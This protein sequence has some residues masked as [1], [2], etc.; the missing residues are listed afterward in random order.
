MFTPTGRLAAAL[1]ALIISI[2]AP[3]CSI[4]SAPQQIAQIRLGASRTGAIA[5]RNSTANEVFRHPLGSKVESPNH[6]NYQR[7]EAV[8]IVWPRKGQIP[9]SN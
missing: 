5:N 6:H 2:N 8:P 1:S 7:S 4:D 9:N 3:K